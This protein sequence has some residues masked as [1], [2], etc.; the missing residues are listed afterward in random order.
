MAASQ[1]DIEYATAGVK[2]LTDI[3]ASEFFAVL[4]QEHQDRLETTLAALELWLVQ[5]TD[6]PPWVV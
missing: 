2:A 4:P 1:A 3:H 5:P 6:T